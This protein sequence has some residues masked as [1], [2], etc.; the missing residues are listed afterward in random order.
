MARLT[1]PNVA[2]PDL[3]GTS[4]I[5]NNAASSFNTGLNSASSLLDSY[6]QG[7][8]EK[9]DS[10]ILGTIAGIS[11]EQELA[12]FINSGELEKVNLSPK[13]RETVL[14]LRNNILA[15]EGARA[16]TR[17][18]NTSTNIKQASADRAAA[19][20][21]DTVNARTELRG[22]TPSVIGANVEGNTQGN[23]VYNPD[24]TISNAAPAT[25]AFNSLADAI[26]KSV[27]L[28]PAQ[29]TALLASAYESQNIGQSRIDT[30][31]GRAAT[32]RSANVILDAAKDP[33]NIRGTDITRA[34]I[35]DPRA[36][37]ANDRI[38]TIIRADELAK[39]PI[40]EVISPTPNAPIP[41]VIRNSVELFKE[42]EA[43]AIDASVQTRLSRKVKEHR[44]D[45]TASLIQELTIGED[46]ENSF[47]TPEIIDWLTLGAT[48]LIGEK[49]DPLNITKMINKLAKEED[50]A[51]SVISTAMT[52]VFQ[53]DPLGTNILERRFD[54]QEIRDYVRNNL[55]QESLARY[56]ENRVT[57]ES[58]DREVNSLVLR[59][60]EARSR[61]L[62]YPTNEV[63][64]TL[65]DQIKDLETKILTATNTPVLQSGKENKSTIESDNRRSE[66]ITYLDRSGFNAQL[67][68]TKPGSP[69]RQTAIRALTSIIQR[70]SS[71]S[72]SQRA[73]LILSISQ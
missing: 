57:T 18:T 65:E 8:Q 37:T 58:R 29:A 69:E 59:L 13:M 46:G 28:D 64:K 30:R 72:P 39:G 45:P 23:V 71:L 56:E 5:L 12:K 48:S 47:Q 20:Y 51:P 22:L 21:L 7:Q 6:A 50:V 42:R 70:D 33:E 63:P 41:E 62:K 40:G 60:G 27:N 35:N 15:N 61:A 10:A 9:A 66:L 19:E 24:D 2:A 16:S 43:A 1:I 14:N 26:S 55:S 44:A 4:S 53:R 67:A 25:P 34:I 11:S 68:Q 32:D 52:E 3:S 31:R 17:S 54:P 49:Y 36:A 38:S 73:N